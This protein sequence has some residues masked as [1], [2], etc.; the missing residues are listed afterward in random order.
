MGSKSFR[1][2]G[3]NQFTKI[4]AAHCRCFAPCPCFASCS[5][6]CCHDPFIVRSAQTRPPPTGFTQLAHPSRCSRST[7]PT[8]WFCSLIFS[9]GLLFSWSAAPSP[10]P[11]PARH[12]VVEFGIHGQKKT[13]P[14][15][16][17]CCCGT[18]AETGFVPTTV[19]FF[20]ASTFLI[21]RS[22]S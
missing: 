5:C 1:Q 13:N 9:P 16:L 6:F 20:A 15:N 12:L 18:E 11:S 22:P 21:L 7:L 4:R 14:A 10:D 17:Q 3:V 2:V 8:V 19:Q